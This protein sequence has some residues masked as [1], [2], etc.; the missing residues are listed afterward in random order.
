MMQ[1]LPHAPCRLQR[2]RLVDYTEIGFFASTRS[3]QIATP[4]RGRRG[5]LVMLCLHTLRADCNPRSQFR[6]GSLPEPLPPHAPCR[7]QPETINCYCMIMPFASTR[8]VQIATKATP[9]IIA[10]PALCLHTLRADCNCRNAQ[11]AI[12]TFQNVC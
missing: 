5:K 3:V 8:S 12:C 11:N 1:G 2:G 9:S 10:P 6:P 4:H 7:L